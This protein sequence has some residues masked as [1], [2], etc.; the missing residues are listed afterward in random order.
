MKSQF[1]LNTEHRHNGITMKFEN[2]NTISI[3]FST[4]KNYS[5]GKTNA[6]VAAWAA[7]GEWINLS[8]NP[9]ELVVGWQTT[10]KV[11]DLI[12]KVKSL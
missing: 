3:Q 1:I 9:K 7:D 2:G 5:D 6:E 4:T 10:D 11:A 8:D 12:Q